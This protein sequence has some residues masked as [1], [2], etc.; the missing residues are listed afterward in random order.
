MKNPDIGQHWTNDEHTNGR[1]SLLA[2][3]TPNNVYIHRKVRLWTFRKSKNFWIFC[4]FLY[5]KRYLSKNVHF[6]ISEV[7]TQ[8]LGYVR[9][10][11]DL[12]CNI[13][14]ELSLYMQ[15]HDFNIFY[16]FLHPKRYF[17][18]FQCGW[19]KNFKVEKSKI[20][21]FPKNALKCFKNQTCLV[22]YFWGLGGPISGQIWWLNVPMA[23]LS[24]IEILVKMH[25]LG[26]FGSKRYFRFFGTKWSKLSYFFENVFFRAQRCL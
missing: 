26:I 17:S 13:W 18:I 4:A 11:Y 2:G 5:P 21:I 7:G 10:E 16:A 8:N 15:N 1:R 23:N 6:G 24:K 19:P 12:M 9:N 20:L 22:E 25:F 3:N 14:R